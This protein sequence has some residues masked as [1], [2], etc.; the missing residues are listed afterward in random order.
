MLLLKNK[1][2]LVNNLPWLTIKAKRLFRALDDVGFVS[3]VLITSSSEWR[4]PTSRHDKNRIVIS[5]FPLETWDATNARKKNV[6][7]TPKYSPKEVLSFLSHPANTMSIQFSCRERY[8][9]WQLVFFEQKILARSFCTGGEFWWNSWQFLYRWCC[10]SNARL[11][12]TRRLE[13][14]EMFKS[15]AFCFSLSRFSFT[16]K[17]RSVNGTRDKHCGGLSNCFFLLLF[18]MSLAL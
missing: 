15:F 10:I 14:W 3:R 16:T 12:M 5:D 18:V 11:E 1:P 17:R 8:F 4:F 6:A 13:S 9:S 2:S 7:I